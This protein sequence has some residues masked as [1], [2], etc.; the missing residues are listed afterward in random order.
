MRELIL[1]KRRVKLLTLL[2]LTVSRSQALP[3]NAYF[4][5]LPRV[6]LYLNSNP[7]ATLWDAVATTY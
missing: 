6:R 1:K 2:T 5:A 7:Q 4:E 3:G